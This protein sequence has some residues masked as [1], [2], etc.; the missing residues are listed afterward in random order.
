MTMGMIARPAALTAAVWLAAVAPLA[1]Q[2]GGPGAAEASPAPPAPTL[3]AEPLAGPVRVDGRLDEAAW[4]GA[5]VFTEFYQR[6]P[7]EGEPASERTEVR[8]LVGDDALYV[9][10][11]MHDAEPHL[12][13]SQLARRDNAGASDF[14]QVNLDANHDHLTAYLFRATP[15]GS[16]MDSFADG[17]QNIDMSWDP[18]WESRTTVDDEGW[19]AEMRIPFSQIRFEAGNDTWGL[20]IIRGIH[21]KFE[22]SYF[23]LIPR[24]ETSG[25]DRYGH[26]TGMSSVQ[27]PSRLEVLPYVLSKAEDLN[28]PEGDPFHDALDRSIQVGLDAK[29]GLTSE[30]TLDATVNPDFGQVELDPAVVNLSAFETFFPE[31]RPFF[32]EGADAFRFGDTGADLNQLSNN[33]FYSR[34]IGRAPSASVGGPGVE[35]VDQPAQTTILGAAKVSGRIAGWTVGVLD[36]LTAREEGRFIDAEGAERVADVEPRANYFAARARRDFGEGDSSIGFLATSATRSF[37]G[38]SPLEGMLHGQATVG[39]VDFT[40]TWDR[41]TWFVNGFVAASRVSGSAEALARTQRSS[42]RYYQRPDAGHVDLDPTRTSLG[43]YTAG[44]GVGRTGGQHWLGSV[45]AWTKSPGW[46]VNDLGFDNRSDQT[47]ISGLLTYRE[48]RPGAFYRNFRIDG[49]AARVWNYDGDHVGTSL[50]VGSIMQFSNFYQGSLRIF[51]ALDALDDQLTRGGPLGFNPGQWT[52]ATSLGTD[53]RRSWQSNV[54]FSVRRDDRESR[55]TNLSASLSVRPVPSLSLSLQPSLALQTEQAQFLGSFA[56]ADF[57][58]TFGRRYLFGTIEQTTTSL[59]ARADWTFSPTLSLQ[60]FVQPLIGSGRFTEFKELARPGAWDWRFYGDDA[61]TLTRD[62]DRVVLDPDGPDAGPPALTLAPDFN[63]RALRGNAVVR[64]EYRPGSALFFVWQ[65]RRADRV[66]NGEYEL[67][68]D[69]DALFGTNAENVFVV[70]A[71]FWFG[72]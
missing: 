52:V 64:W 3:H 34:R 16:V 33:L 7:D 63:L 17:P 66:T 60:L 72:G 71:S 27:E 11:R 32:V 36:A 43:G 55:G 18:V 24:T 2:T 29:L 31:R 46:E 56:D 12:I 51:R 9:G 22:F 30:L 67:G 69:L 54:S 1:A 47:Q 68:R 48:T 58:A 13:R 15:S 62:G 4:Q 44:A 39:G 14:I 10:A 38:E 41:R 65:Q 61:G 50:S 42:A 49:T 6:D 40:H 70:K 35:Y 45:V 59:T 28:F 53:P 20:Q 37:G 26:L 21:R 5:R 8:I 19:T 25:V 57:D 23:A